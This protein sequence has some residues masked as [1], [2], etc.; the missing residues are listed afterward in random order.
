MLSAIHQEAN[1]LI[2]LNE[3]LLREALDETRDLYLYTT[4]QKDEVPAKTGTC[5]PDSQHSAH[6]WK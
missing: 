4:K 6:F 2:P 1:T 3:Q 5:S